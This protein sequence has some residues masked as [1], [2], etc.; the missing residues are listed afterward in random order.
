MAFLVQLVDDVVVNRFEIN[1]DKLTIG[2]HPSNDIHIDEDA[3][4]GYHAVASGS[5]NPH[6]KDYKEYFIE[7]LNSTNGTFVNDE[8][9]IGK[10]RLHHN[11]LLRM[12]W[13][14]FKFIDE[15]EGELEKTVHMIK[16]V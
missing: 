2:R 16:D 5:T 9:V 15:L 8:K 4:S 14:K 7:D 1:N 13:N 3:I 6:F 12:A 11:D 10:V